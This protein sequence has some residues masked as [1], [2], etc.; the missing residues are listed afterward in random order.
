MQGLLLVTLC[1]ILTEKLND[2]VEK[3][4]G[5]DIGNRRLGHWILLI[6]RLIM[7]EEFLKQP[8][9]LRKDVKA[10]KSW[11]PILLRFLKNLVDRQQGGRF[12]LL[13]FHLCTHFAEDILKWGCPSSYNSSTGESNHK[14]LKKHVRRTQ[15]S[16][17]VFWNKQEFVMLRN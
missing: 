10:F 3:F 5:D 9:Y 1:I 4:G 7:V 17:D 6:E 2:L 14:V 8:K 15:R 16:A 11:F 13:K 12:K